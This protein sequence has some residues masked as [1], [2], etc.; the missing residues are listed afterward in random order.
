MNSLALLHSVI[1][2]YV[3][4]TLYR[5]HGRTS[6]DDLKYLLDH[7]LSFT[8]LGIPDKVASHHQRVHFQTLKYLV[9][10]TTEVDLTYRYVVFW[11]LM[12]IAH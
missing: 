12:L 3:S 8:H 10:A 4:T 9:Y 5:R 11:T 7:V 6:A 2:E 1:G